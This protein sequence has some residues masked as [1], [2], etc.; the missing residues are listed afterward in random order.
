[1]NCSIVMTIGLLFL[2]LFLCNNN[3][4]QEGFDSECG[5]G[6]SCPSRSI[7]RVL[8]QKLPFAT[9]NGA[10]NWLVTHP[11]YYH[12]YYHGYFP[13]SAD[14]YAEYS[15]FDTQSPYFFLN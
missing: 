4:S 9:T 1:M 15:P 7:P 12:K 3:K 11:S 6:E 2:I 14:D 8:N 10:L 13:W 5:P